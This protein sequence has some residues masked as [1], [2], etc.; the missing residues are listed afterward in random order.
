VKI[1]W[2]DVLS[3]AAIVAVAA[4]AIVLY[5][6]LPDPMPARWD[7]AGVVKGYLPKT[8][9]I[10][11]YV[12][13]PIV[14]FLLFKVFPAISPRG[15][16]MASFQP[17]TDIIALAATVVV[18]GVDAAALLA[19]SGRHVPLLVVAQLLMGGLFIVLGNYSGKVRRNYFIGIRTPWTLASEEVWARTHRFGGWV[20]V[21]AGIALVALAWAPLEGPA[22]FPL[23]LLG[24]IGVAAVV[25]VVY[26][27]V[28]Y[29]ELYGK[30]TL[31]GAD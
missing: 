5:D 20:F 26:S 19:A 3:V 12:A 7:T 28:V 15:F 14:L 9:G 17:V 23:T 27:Y 29:R 10:A 13:V 16:R 24:V 25:V 11:V 8:A 30:H 21:I 22:A 4:L 6:S 18:A 1:K 31:G 2:T